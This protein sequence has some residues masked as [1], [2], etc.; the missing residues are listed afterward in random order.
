METPLIWRKLLVDGKRIATSE[1]I[2]SLA[3]EIGRDEWRSVKYLQT[4][5]YIVRVLKG[6][7]Y[8]KS[9][10]ERTK[11]T[12]DTSIYEMVA[13]ALKEK[14]VKN[15]YYGLET[16]LKLNLMTH[17]YYMIDY[18]ITDSFRTT[19]IIKILNTEFG[20][21][22][23][24][25]KHFREGIIRDRT[26]RYSD[27]E[28]TVLGLAYRDYLKKKKPELYLGHYKEYEGQLDHEKIQRY[29]A[30]YPKRFKMSVEDLL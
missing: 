29:L 28:K 4:H 21:I 20:F 11:K 30:P 1:E 9:I 10:E 18:V 26:I 25:E 15:W 13:M 2:R 16:A 12:Y 17:E 22:K 6:I 27:R 7:F 14:G 23:R 5:E 8:V 3:K 24:G 19:K